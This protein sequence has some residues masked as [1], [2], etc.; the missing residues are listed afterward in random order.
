MTICLRYARDTPEAED[1]LQEGF[2]RIFA[3]IHQF[4]F[5]GS[6]EGWIKRV[7]VTTCLKKLQKRKIQYHDISDAEKSTAFQPHI[8]PALAEKELIKMISRLPDGYRIVFNLH[9]LD[10]YSHD[11]ISVLLDI[12][13]VTSRSQL[14]KA[15]KTLQKQILANNKFWLK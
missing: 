3:S 15:R 2:I 14:L 5:K 7:V 8:I 12:K 6:F 10:G 4:R 9:V 1:F 13:P 11:E